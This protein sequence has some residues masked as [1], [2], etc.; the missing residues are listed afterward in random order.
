MNP[1]ITHMYVFMDQTLGW[2][3]HLL[4]KSFFGY[5]SALRPERLTES[6]KAVARG[7]R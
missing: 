4:K 3:R 1:Q 6:K 2:E 5:D 7:L